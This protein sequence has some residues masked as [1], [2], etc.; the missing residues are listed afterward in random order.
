MVLQ[1]K[2]PPG[3][4]AFLLSRV[5]LFRADF[6]AAGL[7]AP[8]RGAGFF[9]AGFLAT[10]CFFAA[11]FFAAGFLAGAAFFAAGLPFPLAMSA[12]ASWAAASLASGTRYGEQ[13]T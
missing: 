6:F 2:A 12:A 13:D 10:T 9:A 5:Y 3:G 7:R 8:A 1:Q 4:G 11:A